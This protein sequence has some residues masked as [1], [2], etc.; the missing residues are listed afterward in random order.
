MSISSRRA[1]TSRR[2]YGE[3]SSPTLRIALIGRCHQETT[4]KQLQRRE[5][6]LRAIPQGFQPAVVLGLETL[7][8]LLVRVEL[9]ECQ[10]GTR[11]EAD[12]L[13]A[14]LLFTLPAP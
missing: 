8:P 12:L 13:D 7:H 3:A 9:V 14:G 4:T 1:H 2:K 6:D 10:L 11:P 5:P